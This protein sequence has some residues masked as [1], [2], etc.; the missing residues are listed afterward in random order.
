MTSCRQRLAVLALLAAAGAMLSVAC[1][2]AAQPASARDFVLAVQ[3]PN[4]SGVELRYRVLD[5]PE[6][7][8]PARVE[9]ALARVT[10]PAGASVKFSA[11]SSLRLAGGAAPTRLPADETTTLTVTVVPQAEGLAYLNV[12]TTQRGLTSSTSIPIQTGA[13]KP[14]SKKPGAG[15]LQETPEGAKILVLPAK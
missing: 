7:G 9:V 15:S 2:N 3:K 8:Q 11:D 5:T 1:A 10:D 13:A 12:F 4:G 14:A 6:V